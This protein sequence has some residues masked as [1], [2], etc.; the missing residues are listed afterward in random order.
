M[1]R[2][3]HLTHFPRV[4][5]EVNQRLVV[6][7]DP[8]ALSSPP[9][10][11]R[12]SDRAWAGVPGSGRP[13]RLAGRRRA[14]ARQSRASGRQVWRQPRA[15]RG[16]CPGHVPGGQGRKLSGRPA[17]S[18]VQR[19]G[20]WK[21]SKPGSG[22]PASSFSRVTRGLLGTAVA[23]LGVCLSGGGEPRETVP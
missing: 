4:C 15:A 10:V 19:R 17:P 20:E 1:R 7:G 8:P 9:P 18:L 13:A 6:A 3:P 23:S 22:A 5:L 14:E 21:A 2:R 16:R 11:Q 12:R